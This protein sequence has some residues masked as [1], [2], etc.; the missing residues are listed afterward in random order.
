MLLLL[1]VSEHIVFLVVILILQHVLLVVLM[2][3]MVPCHMIQLRFQITLVFDES[4]WRLMLDGY[5]GLI[6]LGHGIIILLKH[7]L[8]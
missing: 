6:N 1:H 2:V 8:G 4:M 7:I 5:D 3:V